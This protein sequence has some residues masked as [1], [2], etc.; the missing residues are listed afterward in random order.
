[1]D[2]KLHPC[3]DRAAVER[4]G[5]LHLPVAPRCN[6]K[7]HYCDRRYGCV[8]GNRPSITYQILKPDVA[9][10]YAKKILVQDKRIRAIGIAGPGDPLANKKTIETLRLIQQEFP[11]YIKCLCT[12]G[13]ALPEKVA[14]LKEA[15]LNNI[16]ITVNTTDSLIGAKIYA[17]V[18]WKGKAYR[19]EAAARLLWNRQKEG[20][21]KAID[22]GLRVKVNT[23]FI[24]GINEKGL[25]DLARTVSRL[26][27]P[28]MNLVP[29]I[30]L[31][32][33]SHLRAPTRDELRKMRTQLQ[34]FLPQMDWCRQCRAD[35]VGLLDEEV[36]QDRIACM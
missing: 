26:G 16:T 33:F 23:I 2:G 8:N 18:M 34:V 11:N 31:A 13:L 35:A 21:V 25:V 4:F 5:R 14:E 6:I 22:C 7:C 9:L 17:Y 27:V 24:P 3:F 29:L 12:N 28:L 32:D 30:P 19:G 36:M 20:I 15:G 1:M 10:S